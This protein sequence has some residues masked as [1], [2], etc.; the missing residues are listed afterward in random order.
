MVALAGVP[1]TA[2]LHTLTIYQMYAVALVVGIFTVSSTSP[3]SPTCR[4]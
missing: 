1:I 2:Y 4:R 3:T